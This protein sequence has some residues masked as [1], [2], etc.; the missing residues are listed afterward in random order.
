MSLQTEKIQL[1]RLILSLNDRSVL[2]QIKDVLFASKEDWWD[3]ISM[4]EQESI[5]QG[6]K[7]LASGKR[8][9]HTEVMSNYKKWL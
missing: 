6:L 8:K 4:A 3:T 5:N 1:A 2:L 7:E 9:S